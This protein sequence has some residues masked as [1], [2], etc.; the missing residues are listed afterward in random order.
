M[1]NLRNL[2]S[3]KLWGVIGASL[4]FGSMSCGSDLETPTAGGPVAAVANGKCY[5]PCRQG[6][7]RSNGTYLD[8][9]A[10]G[11]MPGCIA[12]ATCDRGTC[13]PA[14]GTGVATPPG[15]A[16][17]S[18]R[19]LA[20]A[21]ASDGGTA[22]DASSV[23][24]SPTELTGKGA[25]GDCTTDL[26]CASHQT[27]ISGRCA[28]DCDFNADCAAG[29]ACYL[30]V[31]RAKCTAAAQTCAA[32][33]SCTLV[34]GQ[35]G[36]CTP[37]A[38]PGGTAT[39]TPNGAL[40]TDTSYLEFTSTV[41]TGKFKLTNSSNSEQKVV[42]R[43]AQEIDFT[44]AGQTVID[45]AN[46]PLPWITLGQGADAPAKVDRLVVN[47]AAAG[48]VDI[49]VADV[50]NSTLSHWEGE[51]V[52]E[53]EKLGRRRIRLSY[54]GS[55]EG[56]WAG[57]MFYFANFGTTGIDQWLAQRDNI[58]KLQLV[59]NAFIKRW[60]AFKQ[61][62][63]TF[64]EFNAMLGATKSESWKGATVK[65]R[66]PDSN[67]PN[68]NA[69]CYMYAP[70]TGDPGTG[71]REYSNALDAFPI[72]SAVAELPIGINIH[73][74]SATAPV[75]EWSGKIISA[76]TLHY[77]G[78][79]ALTLTFEDDPV[80]CT[81]P[82]ENCM[83]LLK[84]KV[85]G[86]SVTPGFFAQILVGGRYPADEADSTCSKA[87]GFVRSQ[88]PWLIPGFD[89]DPLTGSALPLDTTSG[90]LFRY[91]CRDKRLPLEG[92]N[93]TATNVA[94]AASNPIADGRTRK[95]TVEFIDGV[96]VNQSLIFVLF[97]EKF[98]SFLGA[99]D[100]EG[101]GAYGYMLLKKS[102]DAV[103]DATAFTGSS[104]ADNRPAPDL[105]AVSCT[106]NLKKKARIATA[107]TLPLTDAQVVR[108]GNIVLS[109]IEPSATPPVVID[110]ISGEHVHYY[111][112]DTGLIDTGPGGQAPGTADGGVATE[113]GTGNPTPC[114][115]GSDAVFFTTYGPRYSDLST[116]PCQANTLT[117]AYDYKADPD[118]GT[119]TSFS[120]VFATAGQ[121]GTCK[122]WIDQHKNDPVFRFD[123]VWRCHAP[124]SAYC[125]N[126][127]T[128]LRHDKDFYAYT[129]TNPPAFLPL[130]T[131][132]DRAYRYKTKFRNREGKSLGF[133]PT[134]CEASS[135]SATYCYDPAAIQEAKERVDCALSI[136]KTYYSLPAL[137]P[138]TAGTLRQD[139]KNFL[140]KNFSLDIE[141]ITLIQHDGFERL[142]A[143]LLIM[144]ADESYTQAFTAR[145]DLAGLQLA[146]FQGSLLEPGGIDLSGGA[147]FEMFRL[148][149]AAQYYQMALDR[150][151]ALSPTIWASLK[152]LPSEANFITQGTVT[153][154][155]DKLVRASAQKSRAWSEI[156]KRYQSF[157]RPDLARLVV[158]RAYTSAYLESIV[159]SRMMLKVVEIAD[160]A[161]RAQIVKAVEDGQLVSRQGMLAMRDVFKQITDDETVFGYAKDY[162]P[163]PALDPND[164]N[165]FQKLLGM[166][167]QRLEEARS[168]E[169]LALQSKRD[170]DM[171]QAAFESELVSI[172]N[173]SEDQLGSIC[174]TFK[175]DDGNI[176]PAITKYAEFSMRT[177]TLQQLFGS[178]CGFVGNG[179]ISDE[180]NTGAQ[181]KVDFDSIVARQQ[182]LLT[183]IDIERDRVNKQCN[184]VYQASTKKCAA[185]D[186]QTKA[187]CAEYWRAVTGKNLDGTTW[188][189]DCSAVDQAAGKC[190]ASNRC[191]Q[192]TE[193]YEFAYGTGTCDRSVGANLLRMTPEGVF[194][195]CSGAQGKIDT[196][197]SNIRITNGII[198]ESR[199]VVDVMGT[200]FSIA[201]GGDVWTK[202]ANIATTAIYS[203]AAGAAE[204]VGAV[205]QVGVEAAQITIADM[206][207]QIAQFTATENCDNE[208]L[209]AKSNCKLA[210]IENATGCTF[211]KIDANNS[212]ES[213]RIDAEANIRTQML[214]MVQ[215]RLDALKA[216]YAM[217]LSASHVSKLMNDA[218]AAQDGQGE[219]LGMLANK[220]AA[221]TDPNTRIYKNDAI[222][223]ADRTFTSA[224]KAAYKATK[225]FE[226]Y[227]SQSYAHAGDLFLVRT[228]AYGDIS[229]ESYLAGLEDAFTQFGEQYGTPDNRVAIVSLR[230]DIL[231]IA[232]QTG[233]TALSQQDRIDLFRKRLQD[234]DLIDERGYLSI[235][236]S[237]SLEQLSPVTRNHKISY[238]EAEMIGQ[239]LGD[240]VGRVYLV[241]KGTGTV[242]SVG[243]DKTFYSFPARTAVVDTFFSGKRTFPA[244]VYQTRRMKDLPVA[245]TAWQLVFNQ[246]D[247]QVNKDINVDRLSDIRLY[248]YYT[249]FTGL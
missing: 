218:K 200:A 102:P 73:H 166:S 108:L 90:T 80:K 246:R 70:P 243:G 219:A 235:P 203:I 174:G 182:T 142:N 138:A 51:L 170:F 206:Q 173:D 233:G 155:F 127:R 81:Q 17:Q 54:A 43:K 76:E 96:M 164:V 213:A 27:C 220:A 107:G 20:A 238:V 53:S 249:D 74:K 135:D 23:G 244:E 30:H 36:F 168:K 146:N 161:S 72:P 124:D 215:I 144:L 100:P 25:T 39:A 67:N 6:I 57:S 239:D 86:A 194:D 197:N 18:K 66:C 116:L 104:P 97:R 117:F 237:T 95:R 175:G 31:C 56:H 188:T 92:A 28:S 223:S 177:R 137:D 19:P 77:A 210:E 232:L 225:V 60:G 11:L 150:F 87:Q 211:E 112:S 71:I 198:A 228:V 169:Q 120:T 110:A 145:Y 126:D 221:Q 231:K 10:D 14:S 229:L 41:K 222:L 119:A 201:A 114:P 4:L 141:P 184:T 46:H 22:D 29:C 69:G 9:P 240:E 181:V 98:E 113:A 105:L 37:A 186:V 189:E 159:L 190:V 109:G 226:Y 48:S 42:V 75:D 199:R 88:V 26:E 214:G 191:A 129:P 234:P 178:P 89:T 35:N 78:D 47:I 224:V 134:I 7:A 176:Y 151:Y 38:P 52:A 212:C 83:V 248:I 230:D 179:Q 8:C 1:R 45:A 2:G 44:D 153:S 61:G 148:Y 118:A 167:K 147:G 58:A 50:V 16:S 3:V 136:Y 207:R 65:A 193:A 209:A 103:T 180:F 162:I 149:Q 216:Q 13:V 84:D 62:N 242:Q 15:A 154:Y 32:G 241:Q 79:P 133:T 143:E 21:A 128:D 40:T 82:G 185:I 5:T 64:D 106:K 94:F 12:G 152:T 93:A 131:A 158:Q 34:D 195:P 49:T 204:G 227:T 132:I 123:P 59:G 165:A 187:Q 157:N 156:A 33:F 101:F 122:Q 192:Y 217:Q 91:E 140:T 55:P 183:G 68:P 205:L 111:C 208:K 121:R 236:F 196:L 63:I 202:A 163:F 171:N 85:A 115:T 160:P 172:K 24:F 245:N 99:T 139:L 130:E 247:E 125:D